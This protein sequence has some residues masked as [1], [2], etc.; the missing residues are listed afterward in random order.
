MT[1]DEKLADGFRVGTVH[2]D[3]T[4]EH[5]GVPLRNGDRA[6]LWIPSLEMFCMRCARNGVRPEPPI[7]TAIVLP[8]VTVILLMLAVII[9]LAD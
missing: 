6:A 8:A 4:C 1:K 7:S 5:C 3:G 9:G 2:I